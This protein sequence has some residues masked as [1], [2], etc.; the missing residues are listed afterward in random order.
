MDE[1]VV[2][3]LAT[4]GYTTHH[5]HTLYVIRRLIL[6]CDA[7]LSSLTPRSCGFQAHSQSVHAMR[8]PPLPVQERQNLI[9]VFK[10]CLCHAAH[11]VLQPAYT[12]RDTEDGPE[13]GEMLH[14][15]SWV[16]H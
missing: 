11:A 6:S 5:L 8:N 7:M 3:G 13:E 15:A 12:S 16:F 1:A 4:C 14:L 10:S 9:V 2:S